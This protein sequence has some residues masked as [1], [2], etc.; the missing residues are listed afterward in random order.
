[1]PPS[2]HIQM[3]P[4]KLTNSYLKKGTYWSNVLSSHFDNSLDI[5]LQGSETGF[6]R[7]KSK[8]LTGVGYNSYEK[9]RKPGENDES[10]K[11]CKSTLGQK[12]QQGSPWMSILAYFDIV[13]GIFR[14]SRRSRRTWFVVNGPF[15]IDWTI[16]VM[17]V[18]SI[19]PLPFMWIHVVVSFKIIEFN[20]ITRDLRRIVVFRIIWDQCVVFWSMEIFHFLIHDAFPETLERLVWTFDKTQKTPS[21]WDDINC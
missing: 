15:G 17:L 2:V 11:E 12:P 13:Q 5:L 8:C 16:S 9:L 19:C 1:M 14:M 10:L 7:R 6:K 21:Q 18:D 3:W 20:R 4:N